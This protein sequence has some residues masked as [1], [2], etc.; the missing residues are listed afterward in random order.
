MS[1]A[2]RGLVGLGVGLAAAGVATAAGVAARQ[3]RGE[4]QARL[5]VLSPH[6]TYTHTADREM[7]ILADDGVS[8]HVEVDDGNPAAASADKPTVVFS[9]G[10]TLSLRSW[11]LQRRALVEAGYRVVLWDQRS[12]GRSALA[13]AES[14]TIDQLGRDLHRVVQETVPDGPLVLIG[15]SM[16]G[17]TVMSMAEQFPEVVRERVVAAAFVATSAGGENMLTLGFG[18]F[19]GRVLGR[20]GPRLLSRLG[21]RQTLVD[22][23]RRVGREVEDLIVERYSFASPVSPETVRYTADMIM[24]TPLQVMADF[25]PSIDV[26]DKRKALAQFHGIETL[27]LNGAQDLLTPPAHSEAIVRL[28]PGAEHVV[29]E[30]AGHI[31]ML[32]HPE[33]LDEQFLSLIERGMRAAEAGVPVESKPRVRRTLTDL[34]KKRRVADARRTPAQRRRSRRA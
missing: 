29:V 8:L 31:I 7:Q 24:G 34:A 19:V 9:H 20:L 33:V 26:H 10:Y 27:V 17:M 13:P 18:Q 11:V 1:P 23:A 2:N 4:R 3:V 21:T 28:V 22:T 16:G 12:H 14:C 6:G 25:L 30:E 5:S 32:E 15:H